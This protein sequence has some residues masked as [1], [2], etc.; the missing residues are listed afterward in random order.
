MCDGWNSGD[1]DECGEGA[2]VIDLTSVTRYAVGEKI[3]GDLDTCG[4]VV[5]RGVSVND[6]MQDKM[7]AIAMKGK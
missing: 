5:M 6:N 4:W 2:T 3:L 1:C 7:T